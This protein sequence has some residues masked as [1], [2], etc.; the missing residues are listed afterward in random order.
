M[1]YF[2]AL[3]GG[4]SVM[5][6]LQGGGSVVPVERE[7]AVAYRTECDLFELCMLMSHED[8]S[9]TGKLWTTI[10]V[11]W[12]ILLRLDIN[13]IMLSFWKMSRRRKHKRVV[14]GAHIYHFRYDLHIE[15]RLSF[16]YHQYFN[17]GTQHFSFFCQFQFPRLT[18]FMYVWNIVIPVV[19]TLC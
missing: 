18:F 16:N 8:V 2:Q 6:R 1:F 9:Y 14:L 15:K 7:L 17:L 3:Q 12:K 11:F 5:E 4:G 13:S 10:A 19:Q